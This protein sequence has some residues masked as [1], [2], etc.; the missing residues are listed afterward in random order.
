MNK[1]IKK[2]QEKMTNNEGK[3]ILG[4]LTEVPEKKSKQRTHGHGQQCGW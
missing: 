3:D 2:I 1:E 4:W